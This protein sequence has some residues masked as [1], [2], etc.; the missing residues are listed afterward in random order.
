MIKSSHSSYML[1]SP[2]GSK[3][4]GSGYRP[5]QNKSNDFNDKS[6]IMAEDAPSLH[7]ESVPEKIK[8]QL[9]KLNKMASEKVYTKI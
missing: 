7:K 1:Q 8:M 2:E 6:N 4:I 5:A 3:L 9:S